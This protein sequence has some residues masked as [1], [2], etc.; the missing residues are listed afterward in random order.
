METDSLQ[1]LTGLSGYKHAEWN[2][3]MGLS[4]EGQEKSCLR[5]EYRGGNGQH[6]DQALYCI[7]CAS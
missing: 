2:S 5:Q 7:I 4:L 1:K 6:N 3:R